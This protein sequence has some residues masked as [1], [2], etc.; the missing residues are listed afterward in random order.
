V[1]GTNMEVIIS[2]VERVIE[3]SRDLLARTDGPL[4]RDPLLLTL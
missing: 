1:A 2:V 3:A 4:G